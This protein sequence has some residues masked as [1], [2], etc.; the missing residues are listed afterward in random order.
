MMIFF[1]S[2]FLYLNFFQ[3]E[4]LIL[5]VSVQASDAYVNIL[6]IIVFFSLNLNVFDMFLLK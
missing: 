5:F 3:N 6:S 4:T 1:K 2:D